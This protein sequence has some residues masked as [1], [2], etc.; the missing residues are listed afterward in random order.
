MKL[1][2]NDQELS[3]VLTENDTLATA[4][5]TVQQDYIAENEVLAAVWIDGEALTA[6]RLSA[7]KDRQI[8]DFEEARVEAPQR[9]ILAA[10]GLR[11]LAAGLKESQEDRKIIVDTIS[12]GQTKQAM[13]LLAGYL[14]SWQAAQETLGSAARLMAINILELPAVGDSSETKVRD[15]LDTLTEQLQELRGTL[16]AEDMVLLNDILEYEFSE[17][18]DKWHD[19]LQSLADRIENL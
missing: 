7:W 4:L 16:T 11:T 10:T 19:M 2:V 18:A 17:L 9:Q 14:R 13:G 6:E 12:Q 5:S 8:C 1:F 15:L 3:Q